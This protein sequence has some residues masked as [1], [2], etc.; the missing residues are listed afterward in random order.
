[1]TPK[2][3]TAQ[4]RLAKALENG[5][6]LDSEEDTLEADAKAILAADPELARALEVGL[7]VLDPE[8]PL[9]ADV[10]WQTQSTPLIRQIHPE[11]RKRSDEQAEA[12]RA[13]LTADTHGGSND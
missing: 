9:L 4:E 7:A 1:M 8:N 12:F 10:W 2:A 3:T 6:F 13:A 5:Q 11:Y